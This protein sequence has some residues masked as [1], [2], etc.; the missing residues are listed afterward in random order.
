MS[1]P[2]LV[3]LSAVSS[4][5]KSVRSQLRADLHGGRGL[6]VRVQ[7]DF[8]LEADT[9]TTLAKLEKYIEGCDAVVSLIGARS[10]ACPTPMEAAPLPGMLSKPV[11]TR[12]RHAEARR[13]LS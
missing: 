13:T 2:F 7:E 6:E 1:Q 8:R 3:F 12:P 11:I 9:E 5:F 4:E 10:A